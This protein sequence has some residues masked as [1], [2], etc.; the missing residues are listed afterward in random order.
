MPGAPPKGSSCG[1]HVPSRCQ[2]PPPGAG[3][4]PQPPAPR[5]PLGP[6]HP[7]AP[8]TGPSSTSVRPWSD[9]PRRRWAQRCREFT[10]APVCLGTVLLV[11]PR[12]CPSWGSQVAGLWTEV[13][14]AS[15]PGRQHGSHPGTAPS[16]RAPGGTGAS[17]QAG[18]GQGGEYLTRLPLTTPSILHCHTTALWAR[19][20]RLTAPKLRAHPV[21]RPWGQL[22]RRSG[23]ELAE[24]LG[25]EGARGPES[26]SAAAALW[27]GGR[28][29]QVTV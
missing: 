3:P 4:G 9:C 15:G 18:R 11:S 24:L 2:L 6:P 5:G 26:V 8:P 16:P 13:R 19:C 27:T 28:S 17:P 20:G 21:R 25:S 23:W 1:A 10:A 22:G 7:A 29:H 12:A 14:G